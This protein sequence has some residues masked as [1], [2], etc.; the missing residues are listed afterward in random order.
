MDKTSE[1]TFAFLTKQGRKVEVAFD[2]PATSSDGGAVL[3]TPILERSALLQRLAEIA[4]Q[5]DRRQKSRVQHDSLSVI[6]PRVAMICCGYYDV[7]DSDALRVDPAM[8]LA[9]GGT[10]GQDRLASQPTVANRW[11]R[12]SVHRWQQSGRSVF[13]GL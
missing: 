10:P 1:Q 8:V 11:R 3:L 2:E 5:E 13:D 6:R 12:G 7:N 4:D 9:A